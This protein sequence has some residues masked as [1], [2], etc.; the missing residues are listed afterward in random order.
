LIDP[1]ADLR[2]GSTVTGTMRVGTP[3]GI[4][5]PS[6]ALLEQNGQPAVFVFDAEAGTVELRP[7]NVLRFNLATALIADGLVEGEVVVTAG[8]QALRNGQRVRLAESVR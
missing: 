4:E 6:T 8:V 3:E 7:V 1:P 2:L 5:L